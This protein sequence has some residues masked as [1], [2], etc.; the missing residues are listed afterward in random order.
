MPA[1]TWVWA[2]HARKESNSSI[3]V[4]FDLSEL[5]KV[6]EEGLEKEEE[7]VPIEEVKALQAQ[8]GKLKVEEGS[9]RAA[10]AYLVAAQIAVANEAQEMEDTLNKEKEV[11][12]AEVA[13]LKEA[14]DC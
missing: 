11:L 14:K 12:Q 10:I 5:Y 9:F 3:E 4:D 2:A 1:H 7:V 6:L 8:K 13:K